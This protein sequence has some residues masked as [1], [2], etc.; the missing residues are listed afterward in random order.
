[1]FQIGF[2]VKGIAV[3]AHSGHSWLFNMHLRGQSWGVVRDKVCPD[4]K[5]PPCRRHSNQSGLDPKDTGEPPKD[6]KQGRW[7]QIGILKR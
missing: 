1:M 6:F 7:D 5:G 4:L 2:L 3:V